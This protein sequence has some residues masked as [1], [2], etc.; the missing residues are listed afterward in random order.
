MKNKVVATELLEERAKCNFDQEELY[1]LYYSDPYV[2][3]IR[4]KA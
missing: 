3:E 1:Q 4:D 2:R